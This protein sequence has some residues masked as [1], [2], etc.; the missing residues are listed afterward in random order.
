[1]TEPIH[2]ISLGAGVQS[3]TLALMAS[4]GEVGPLPYAAIFADTQA[5]PPG[6][7][8]WLDWLEGQL[9]FPVYRV[10]A[11]SLTDAVLKP[12]THLKTGARYFK[13]IIPAYVQNKD[14]TRGITGR[15]CTPDFKLAPLF[16][17]ARELGQIKRGQKAVGVVS[18]IGISLDEVSRMKPSKLPWAKNRFPLIEMEMTRHDCLRWMKSKGYPT[19]PRSACTYCPFHSDHEWRTM[20]NERPNEFAEAVAFEK[21]FQALRDTENGPNRMKG[22]LY[23]HDSLVPL[24][25]I[26]FSEDTTQGQLKFHNECEGLCGV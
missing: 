18:W 7:Y 13:N 16:K 4:D 17:K 1:M 23:L 22:K 15:A 6:V 5:E 21:Q 3:S 12:R 9:R 11:G 14:G 8:Q 19:P 2:I 20:K 25:Q 24:D 26:D 10:T